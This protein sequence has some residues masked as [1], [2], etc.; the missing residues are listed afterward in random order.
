[1]NQLSGAISLE[2][3]KQSAEA[4]PNASRLEKHKVLL[5][6]AL[7]PSTSLICKA[8]NNLSAGI[9]THRNNTG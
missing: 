8:M 7:A 3:T 9:V 5:G 2:N 4:E 6:V 1:M